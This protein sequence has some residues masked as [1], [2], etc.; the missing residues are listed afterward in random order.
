[1]K[2]FGLLIIGFVVLITATNVAASGNTASSGAQNVMVIHMDYPVDAGSTAMFQQALSSLDYSS[3][4][5]VVIEMNTPGGLL[6]DMNQTVSLINQTETHI[7]VYT[8]IEPD[9][10]GASAG[11]YIAMATDTIFMGPG[12]FIGPSTPIVSEN[13]SGEQQHVTD[14]MESF[15]VS[16]AQAHHRNATAAFSMVSN[17]TAYSATGA[18]SIGLVNGMADN[19]SQFMSD[20]NLTGYN[21]VNVNEGVYDQFLSALSNS[22]L[23]GLLLTIGTLAI[24]LDLYHGTVIISVVG[25]IS[26]GLGLVGLEVVGAAPLGIFLIIIGAVIMLLEFKMGHGIALVTGMITALVGAFL[27]TPDYISYGSSSSS[28]GPFSTNN[29]IIAVIFAVVALFI[30]F[31]L[32]QLR[33]GFQSKRY[34]GTESLVGKEAIS[35]SEITD[36]GWIS[37]EGQ[38]WQAK[39]DTG[40]I[41][42][43]SDVIIVGRD[44]LKLIVRKKE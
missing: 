24:L 9:G 44:G 15:M 30:A 16:M 42:E 31:Y 1:M 23:D 29:I 28:N 37:V 4:K 40:A 11:S 12:S 43:S 38:Q 3:F 32:M 5:A 8:Y 6:S 34:T 14:A 27:L 7:P 33:K 36:H 35:K 39:S 41:P 26:I 25:L 21:I 18:A 17:N 22:F 19:F 10:W 13:I 20:M 2:V